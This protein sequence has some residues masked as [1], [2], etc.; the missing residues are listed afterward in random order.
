MFTL[1]L[2]DLKYVAIAACFTEYL[3][4]MRQSD[5]RLDIIQRNVNN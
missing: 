4:T 5:W 2:P 3:Y 1:R